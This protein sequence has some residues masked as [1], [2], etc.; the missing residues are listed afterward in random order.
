MTFSFVARSA[1]PNQIRFFIGAAFIK[2]PNVIN[3]RTVLI[4]RTTVNDF[5][6]AI[7]AE[8]TNGV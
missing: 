7:M 4:V 5:S 3:G 6:S 8:R 2:R 1:R